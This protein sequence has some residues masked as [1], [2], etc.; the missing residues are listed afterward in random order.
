[1]IDEVTKPAD[2][3]L[4]LAEELHRAV[5]ERLEMI[6]ELEIK[7]AFQ[8]DV[9]TGLRTFQQIREQAIMRKAS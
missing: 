3:R 2:E 1:M 4:S 5:A 9:V 8:N 7:S 6:Q